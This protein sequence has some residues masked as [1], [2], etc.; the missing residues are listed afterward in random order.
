MASTGNSI[1]FGDLTADMNYASSGG[2]PVRGVFTGSG[3]PSV[4]R[5]IDYVSITS[6]G[7]A[8]DFGDLLIETGFAG[9]VSDSH[10]GL[11]GF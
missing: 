10:G 2:N 6:L 8:Q 1:Q 9:A 11:G 7:N 3:S 4:S 5:N